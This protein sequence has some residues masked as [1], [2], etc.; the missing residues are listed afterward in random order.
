MEVR[1]RRRKQWDSLWDS[2]QKRLKHPK[3]LE[4]MK[5]PAGVD[6][7]TVH[8]L[9][10]FWTALKSSENPDVVC[11]GWRLQTRRSRISL[12]SSCPVTCGASVPEGVPG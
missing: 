7:A 11:S 6:P 1:K 8:P 5:P 10:I 4:P 12:S 2:Q 9:P 3:F